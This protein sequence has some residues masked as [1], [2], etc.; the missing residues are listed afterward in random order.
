MNAHVILIT[1]RQE[2]VPY[3]GKIYVQPAQLSRDGAI[4]RT[5]LK[6]QLLKSLR[7]K[8]INDGIVE[9]VDSIAFKNPAR[10]GTNDGYVEVDVSCM[11]TIYKPCVGEMIDMCVNHVLREGVFGTSGSIRVLIP[12]EYA[13][14]LKTHVGDTMRVSVR[15]V[16]YSGD[17][18]QCIC[19]ANDMHKSI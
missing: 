14:T 5:F 6:E 19:D 3:T 7:N 13:G 4:A 17:A 11:L 12:V 15:A 18:F 8:F 10:I 2:N 9:E 1:M 16:R